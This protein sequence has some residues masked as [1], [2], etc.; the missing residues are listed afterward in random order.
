MTSVFAFSYMVHNFIITMILSSCDM[1]NVES[2]F[3]F[4]YNFKK[5]S[6]SKY[7]YFFF[8]FNFREIY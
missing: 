6:T 3:N 1:N 5:S 2:E 7:P 4:S 8:F